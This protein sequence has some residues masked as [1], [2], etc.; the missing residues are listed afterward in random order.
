MKKTKTEWASWDREKFT[1]PR[2]A[3][4]II[5]VQR[6]WQDGVFQIGINTYSKTWMFSDVNY[7]LAGPGQKAAMFQAYSAVINSLDTAGGAKVTIFNKRNRK[8]DYE[9][10]TTMQMRQDEQDSYREE[11]NHVVMDKA[12]NSSGIIQHKYITLSCNAK[13][14]QEARS[15]FDDRDLELRSKFAAIGSRITS[16][17]AMSRLQVLSDFYRGRDEMLM[18][19]IKDSMARGHH[20]K[21]TICPEGVE[22]NAEYIK[23][24]NRY[25]RAFYL[26]E[27]AN[28]LSDRF[29]SELTRLSMD[30]VLSIDMQ[31]VHP[32]EAIKMVEDKLFAVECNL[33]SWQKKQNKN[34]NFSA[35][36]PYDIEQQRTLCKDWLDDLT[37]RDQSMMLAVVTILI[38]ADSLDE[39][40]AN[41]KTL[42]S[43]ASNRMCQVAKLTYQQ[44]DGINTALPVG[45]CRL[46]TYKT[47]TTAGIAALMPFTVQ[48]IS[49]VGGIFM[50]VNSLSKN[51][52]ICNRSRLKNQSAFILGVPGSG[53]SFLT[54][55]LIAFIMMNNTDDILICD[56]EG[57]YSLLVEAMG[58][59]GQIV[60]IEAGGHDRLNP[61]DMVNTQRDTN[62]IAIKSEFV[63]S[64]LEQI[65]KDSIGPRHKSIIDRC[66]R[67]IYRDKVKYPTPTLTTL[68]E[69]LQDQPEEEAAHIALTMELYTQG[70]LDIFGHESNVSLNKRVVVF[71]LYGLKDQMKSAG[72]LVVIDAI[73]NRVNENQKRG[74]RTWIFVDEFHQFFENEYSAQFFT[75]AW[76]QFRKRNVF[77]TGITQNAEYLLS[78]VEASSMLG[79]SEFVVMLSQAAQDREKLVPLLKISDEMV[80]YI[81]DVESGCGLLKYGDIIIPFENR[82]PEDTNLYRLMST[83]PQDV[84]AVV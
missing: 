21:D 65:D 44:L 7:Q 40:E 67:Q 16:L 32:D 36:I 12:L 82:W 41:T 17:D 19:D 77:P 37:K 59:I 31:R 14:I 76:R 73:M 35:A 72:L 1:I 50:G 74:K 29:V 48:D 26:K 15:Y 57:E 34:N 62:P 81:S 25:C 9:E 8:E 10:N 38:T 79:N 80:R 49:D 64:L 43:A 5:P 55:E 2:S 45:C 11:Y 84:F 22:R 75:S 28:N 63:L 70:S 66:L 60:R 6:I 58:D 51:L 56:P 18:Y 53:K 52:I 61:L 83:K 42:M 3:Q 54:K 30:L 68:R 27:F 33:T 20:F 78:S 24:G 39:L 47:F 71:D 69:V 4:D 46:K 23:L 13:S